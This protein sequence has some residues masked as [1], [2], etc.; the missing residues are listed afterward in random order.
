MN[1][2]CPKCG[3]VRQME[4][5][6]TPAYECPSCGIIYTKYENKNRQEIIN[7]SPSVE[8]NDIDTSQ[9]TSYNPPKK[10]ISPIFVI[11]LIVAL[12]ISF[13]GYQL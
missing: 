3:A 6:V 13:V 4:D 2:K 10:V 8:R 9:Q 12:M 5:G 11:S 1:K 7:D